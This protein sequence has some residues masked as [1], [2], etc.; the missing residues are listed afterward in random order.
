MC[1]ATV[2]GIVT[3][4]AQ[5]IYWPIFFPEPSNGPRGLCESLRCLVSLSLLKWRKSRI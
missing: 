1:P 4:D 2:S 3:G 5:V